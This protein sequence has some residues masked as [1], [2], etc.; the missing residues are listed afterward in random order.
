LINESSIAEIGAAY[1]NFERRVQLVWD[2]NIPLPINL[3]ALPFCEL[4]G[5]EL[6]NWNLGLQLIKS[7][8]DFEEGFQRKG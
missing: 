2:K 1:V 7:I 8:K 5:D 4:D 6:P 3:K